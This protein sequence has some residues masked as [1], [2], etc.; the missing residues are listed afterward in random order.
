MIAVVAVVHLLHHAHVHAH[1]ASDIFVIYSVRGE[2]ARYSC[3]LRNQY[4]SKLHF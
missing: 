1:R 2:K 4:G 3:S